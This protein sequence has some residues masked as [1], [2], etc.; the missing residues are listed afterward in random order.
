M[1]E[2]IHVINVSQK[3]L[4]YVENMVLDLKGKLIGKCHFPLNIRIKV[5]WAV[6]DSNQ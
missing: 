4:I 1:F 5:W 6:L 2:I 3:L